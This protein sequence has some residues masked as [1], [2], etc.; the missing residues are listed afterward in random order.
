M[1]PSAP[2]NIRALFHRAAVAVGG[3]LTHPMT[4]MS[5]GNNCLIWPD[6]DK[7]GIVASIAVTGII[8]CKITQAK[9]R[10]PNID[11]HKISPPFYILAGAN[12]FTAFSILLPL[13]DGKTSTGTTSAFGAAASA[14]CMGIWG[15][16]HVWRG[17]LAQRKFKGHSDK[18]RHLGE[19][20]ILYTA[21][22]DVMML[23][24]TCLIDPSFLV[25]APLV[26]GGLALAFRLPEEEKQK[27]ASLWQFARKHV[28]S[29]RVLG[30][31]Y[32]FMA[33][34]AA[35]DHASNVAQAAFLWSCAFA[36]FEPSLNRAL[37]PDLRRI[38]TR[39][40]PATP[41]L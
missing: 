35:T 27:P 21:I 9:W 28:T 11:T 12:F 31:S 32:F 26:G 38:A 13:I 24:K 16:G 39:A 29:A 20:P 34:M 33:G 41:R 17:H 10:D 22:A 40:S 37:I 7:A 25:L 15:I 18:P 14:L 36:T 1:S 4:Y 6:A 23:V 30:L 3:V 8:A 19:N 5:L 2:L